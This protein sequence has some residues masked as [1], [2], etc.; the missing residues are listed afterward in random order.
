[1]SKC[2]INNSDSDSDNSD[3]ITLIPKDNS[4]LPNKKKTYSVT[5]L[6]KLIKW[7]ISNK[8]RF[9]TIK[10]EVTNLSN[11]HSN[12]YF[13]LKDQNSKIDCVIWKS[14]TDKLDRELSNGLKIEC[15]GFISVYE[16]AGKYQITV[17]KVFFDGIGNLQIQFQKLKK[18]FE[19]L[20]YF[21][22]ENKKNI[23]KYSTNIGIV[24]SKSG[25]ALQDMLS[26]IKRRNNKLNLYIYDCKVQGENCQKEI[27]S[28]IDYFQ[29]V[30]L[31]IIIIAR[32]G[33]SLE[34]LWGFNEKDVVESIYRSKKPLIS[35]VGHEIDYTLSDY[36]SDLRAI[37]P[38]VAAEIVAFNLSEFSDS[39]NSYYSNIL[40]NITN[41]L[42]TLNDKYTYLQQL[43]ISYSPK[44]IISTFSENLNLKY[45]QIKNSFSII[46]QNYNNKLI[47]YKKTLKIVNYENILKK[48]YALIKNKDKII[49]SIDQLNNLKHFQIEFKDGILD[50]EL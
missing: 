16:K 27:S 48:G 38:S 17:K 40:Q 19:L 5:E 13:S 7:V 29:N 3:E 32:G 14:S 6:N 49:T 45:E 35:G 22:E 28:G 1:M 25:A 24:T 9:L 23:P 50:F 10:G 43:S 39:I 21:N 33:G 12:L 34:D 37:T 44:N 41:K 31:D 8:I 18:H 46:L 26:V 20:G 30:N 36:T 2:L 11:S 4:D 42:N 47:L 15:D